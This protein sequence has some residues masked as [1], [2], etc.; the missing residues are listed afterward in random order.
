MKVKALWMGLVA[1][2]LGSFVTVSPASAVDIEDFTGFLFLN[3]LGSGLKGSDCGG[4]GIF[5]PGAYATVEI[6]LH[7]STTATIKFDGLTNGAREYHFAGAGGGDVGKN[8]A[9]LVLEQ[10][11]VSGSNLTWST[12]TGSNTLSFHS[13]APGSVDGVGTYNF[14][15]DASKNGSANLVDNIHFDLTLT[16]GT[17]SCVRHSD[18]GANS[19]IFNDNLVNVQ[20]WQNSITGANPFNSTSWAE[21]H[22]TV[23]QKSGDTLTCGGSN[24]TSWVGGAAARGVPEPGTL[25]LLGSSVL[26][27]GTLARRFKK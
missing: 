17:W 3:P 27:L 23:C 5:C 18:C 15:V 1:V 6:D 21:G 13:G 7:T 4:A 9:G 20:D 25:A 8:I 22:M 24:P 11:S 16:S 12:V 19:V 2:A 26:L 10:T 14:G